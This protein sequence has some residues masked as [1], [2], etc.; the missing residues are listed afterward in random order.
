MS[1]LYPPP[2]WK[3]IRS[4]PRYEISE[5]GVVRVKAAFRNP[6]RVLNRFWV[7][8][9]RRHNPCTDAHVDQPGSLCVELQMDD[10][11]TT[12]R[13]WKLME[14]YWPEI[15]YPHFWRRVAPPPASKPDGTDGRFKLTA[16]QRLEILA[17]PQS[18]K[19]LAE[20]YGVSQRHVRHI[21]QTGRAKLTREQRD[22]IA[23]HKATHKATAKKYG[24][25]ERQIERIRQNHREGKDGRY[26]P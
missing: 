16:R 3:T 5:E 11:H 13:I 10:K 21:R 12:R 9:N 8:H 1:V 19:E 25:S 24:V 6:L 17:S 4:H 7:T 20:M 23:L 22:E 14:R 26:Y 18:T 2:R 15:K